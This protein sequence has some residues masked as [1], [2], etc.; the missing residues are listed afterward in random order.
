MNKLTEKLLSEGYTK[1]RHP[2]Y[3]EW[4]SYKDFE[5]TRQFLAGTVWETPCGLLKNGINSYN[6]MSH[7]GVTYCPENDN[8]RY[9]CPYY[10]EKPCHHRINTNKL[11][12]CNCIYHQ[13]DRPYNY[14]Q[15]V[16]KLWDEWNK[17]Q[18]EAW[19]K[20]TNEYGYCACM[21]WDRPS[22]QYN[23]KYDIDGCINYGCQNEVCAITKKQRN[24]KKV[25]I[26][27]DILRITKYKK[28]LLEHEIKRLEKGVKKFD[29]P[30]AQT[31][32]EIWFKLNKE[33]FKPNHNREDRY[34]LFLSE[35]HGKSG[36]GEYDW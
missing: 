32:A 17:I 5:Y 36:F 7:L 11:W 13:T 9:G 2:D 29:N 15:S 4:S 16:E 19:Q 14:E 18:K 27:Y 30:I 22:R 21:R 8:P 34:N 35:H 10:D 28:G 3:V 6:H 31:D 25:N 24:L 12:G 26:Y 23:P 1:D 20:A 33:G